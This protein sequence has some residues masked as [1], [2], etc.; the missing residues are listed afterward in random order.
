MNN[1]N[2]EEI[3]KFAAIANDW[4]DLNG[5]MKSLHDINPFRLSYIEDNTTLINKLALDVGCGGGILTESLAQKNA[6]VTGLD[7]TQELIDAAISHA[8]KSH[9]NINYRCQAV[10]T[11]DPAEQQFDIIT[12]MEMLEHVP[13]PSS[14]VSACAKL[15]TPSGK[16]FF[17]TINRNP[18]SF[19]FAIL[20]A[21]YFLRLLPRGTHSYREFIRPS[22][23][24]EWAEAADLTL[25]SIK[26]LQYNPIKSKFR[27]SN[28]VS[29][30]YL[31]CF[32]HA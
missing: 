22:E 31:A 14:V 8:Q 18:K 12:C 7:M 27:L 28:D 25:E 13:D 16:I 30:N 6:I 3:K 32:S 11:L 20:G 26:G 1:Y 29:V 15:V 21:E 24:V 9:L 5:P 17:S 2:P 4:W 23:L 19:L 10:E